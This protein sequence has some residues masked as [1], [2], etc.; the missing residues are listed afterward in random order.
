MTRKAAMIG[1]LILLAFAVASCSND[2]SS[3]FKDTTSPQVELLMPLDG[4][5]R[6][7]VIDVTVDVNDEYG[8]E[9]VELL[10]GGKTVETSTTSPYSF[11]YD[12][13]SVSDGTTVTFSVMAVDKSGNKTYSDPVVVTKGESKSPVATI[14]EPS[15]TVTV[16]QGDEV[17]FEGTATDPED[18]EM[19]SY[20]MSWS[21]NLQGDL[22]NGNSNKNSTIRYRGFVIGDHTITLTAQDSDGN[23]ATDTVEIT[24]TDNDKDYAYVQEGRYT[25][26]PPLFSERSVIIQRPFIISKKEL[27]L[28]EF[29]ENIEAFDED[30]FEEVEDREFGTDPDETHP[31]DYPDDYFANWD[32][33]AD[34]PAVYIT[35]FEFVM[36]CMGLSEQ[37]G[38]SPAYYF[39]DRDNEIVDP[40]DRRSLGRTTKVILK[41]TGGGID[42]TR[43]GWR[44]P[45]EA[46]WMVAAAGGN[47]GKPYPWG[48]DIP[49]GRCNTMD[50]PSPENM[51]VLANGRG[52]SPVDAYADYV[53]PFGLYNIA[54]NVAELTSD[55]FQNAFPSGT[56][57]VGFSDER[58]VEYVV[59]GGCWYNY[60]V[61][62]KIPMRM[63]KMWYDP[64]YDYKG[65]GD[66]DWGIGVRLMRNLEVGEA[67]W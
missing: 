48:Y 3:G 61:E 24:V 23:I 62:V 15:S 52:I 9:K 26:G 1:L 45:T 47:A 11:E 49:A 22:Y 55:I 18:G 66:Y 40:T 21:S 27:S 50:D 5:T 20:T 53:N 6:E 43:N 30:T 16:M 54:G 35:Y 4:S 63:E 41:P 12:L 57:Y 32:Q 60:G 17:V 29:M 14:L 58:D 39:L 67:P 51:L 8:I 42:K 33:Y 56:D 25:I 37:D 7:G 28:G 44:F 19:A 13:T 38:L 64:G 31:T 36:Y 59:K 2:A 10:V 34:Y 46:E 65:Q